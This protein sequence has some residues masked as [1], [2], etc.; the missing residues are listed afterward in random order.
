MIKCNVTINGTVSRAATV[1]TNSEGQTFIC[2]GVKTTIPAKSG[3][4]K[5][6]E[7][8]VSMDGGESD[9]NPY[10][11]GT[12]VEMRGTLTFRKRSDNLYLNFH[13]DAVDFTPASDKDNIEGDIEFRGTI[14][15]QVAQRMGVTCYDEELVTQIAKE[16]G[17]SQSFIQSFSEEASATSSFLFTLNNWANNALSDQIYITQR[18][19][20]QDLA[21]Q[22][23]CVIVGRCADYILKDRPD[24]L[25]TFIHA[26]PEFRADRI[27]RLYGESEVAPEKR[28][29]DKDTRRANNYRHYTGR[30]WGTA[31]NYHLCLDSSVI[32]VEKCADIILDL[33]KDSENT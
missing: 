2:F 7:I 6:V 26:S 5:Q 1:R 13:A 28:L 30:E 29:S 33:V 8:S 25:H 11:V 32:G 22:G 20:I 3:A 23:P 15:K 12:K 31:Q 14:G 24:C 4:G 19:I 18:K 27:V 21:E 10:A 9:T 17:M 16:S